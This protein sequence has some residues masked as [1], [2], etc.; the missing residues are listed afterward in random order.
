M[1]IDQGAS[2]N[3][4]HNNIDVAIFCSPKMIVSRRIY[5]RGMESLQMHGCVAVVTCK[6]YVCALLYKVLQ[7]ISISASRG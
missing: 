4:I 7:Y 5:I 6:S 1:G 3:E 2:F